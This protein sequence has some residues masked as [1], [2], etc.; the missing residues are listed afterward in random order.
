M[1][2]SR[3]VV[4]GRPVSTSHDL[5]RE[6]RLHLLFLDLRA[7]LRQR[8]LA[9]EF[10][11]PRATPAPRPKR[12]PKPANAEKKAAPV[13]PVA[14]RHLAEE[15]D[16]LLSREIKNIAGVRRR[17]G[18]DGGP[19][20]RLAE[21]G[22]S[23]GLTRERVRQQEARVRRAY[24]GFDTHGAPIFS[25]CVVAIERY[26]RSHNG[27]DGDA[28]IEAHLR[29]RGLLAR[30]SRVQSVFAL[31]ELFGTPLAFER[32]PRLNVIVNAHGRDVVR[33]AVEH[34]CVLAENFFASGG[35]L[36][37]GAVLDFLVNRRHERLVPHVRAHIES[38]CGATRVPGTTWL[39]RSYRNVSVVRAAR[40]VLSV[41]P[42]IETP[43][44][45]TAIARPFRTP[46]IPP[47]PVLVAVLLD[48]LA[49]MDLRSL[50]G[51]KTL[52]ARRPPDPIDA[53]A[54]NE[55]ALYRVLADTPKNALPIDVLLERA[56]ALGVGEASARHAM[57]YSPIIEA[58]ARRI[59]ALLGT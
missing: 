17:L 6:E 20:T 22:R 8:E 44:L 2:R 35:L 36:P 12:P 42:T 19:P 31:A 27:W 29:E 46:V 33:T 55:Y 7:D 15:I 3:H 32:E 23:A 38:L 34:V 58:P 41:C 24:T 26:L 18:L 47:R 11:K 56:M 4:R 21:A 16:Q 5:S 30:G 40:K 13:A 49:D 9:G 28:A 10:T 43:R 51:G 37:I 45:A 48:A 52:R 57:Q 14:P 1:R 53:L 59:R 25:N 39:R 50:H 54:K